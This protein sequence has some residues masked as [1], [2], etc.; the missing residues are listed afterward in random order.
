MLRLI[1]KA[2]PSPVKDKIKYEIKLLRQLDRRSLIIWMNKISGKKLPT[3]VR[4]DASSLCQL[5]CRGC[6]M[7]K[8]NY[9]NRGKGYLKFDDFAKFTKKNAF[10][11][12]IELS[13]QGEI[14]LNPDLLEIIKYSHSKKI[15]LSAYNGVNFN[16]VSDEV[17]EALVKYQFHGITVAIDGASQEIYSWYRRNGDFNKVIDNVKK[18][19]E[20]KEKY[21][22]SHPLVYWQ[23]VVLES[24]QTESEI[25]EA[26][27]MAKE[28][29]CEISFIK[30]LEGFI[31]DD[32]EMIE[33]ETKLCYENKELRQSLSDKR[34]LA[35]IQL[36]KVPQINYDGRLFGCCFNL[37]KDFGLNIFELG[38]EKS[39]N[40]KIIKNT[41]KMLTGGKICEESPCKDCWLYKKI[42]NENNFITKKE[43]KERIDVYI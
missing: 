36:W 1:K 34:V 22:S 17:L 13:N 18:L 14:F 29:N 35:C 19:N 12:E 28:L 7:R 23:Y 39:L 16:T 26:K 31:P 42:A 40:S 25:R 8:L 2:I 6:F 43:I 3:R 15:N 32:I 11:K 33:R 38:L 4:I 30:D 5:N 37:D 10:V 20:Y 24:N 27:K 21:N 9:G 41:K